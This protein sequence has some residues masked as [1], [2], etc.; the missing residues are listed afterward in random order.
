MEK[1][2]LEREKSMS[3]KCPINGDCKEFEGIHRTLYG[4]DGRGGLNADMDKKADVICLAKYIRK[5]HPAWIGIVIGAIAI[6]LIISF[7]TLS[8]ANE[9]N[10][11]VFAKKD[12]VSLLE[13]NQKIIN[14]KLNQIQEKLEEMKATQKETKKDVNSH[15]DEIKEMIRDFHRHDDPAPVH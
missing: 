3:E 12:R 9:I 8:K 13:S 7:W 6:P 5:P 1:T 2:D 4:T 14:L 10:P 11:H 15:L